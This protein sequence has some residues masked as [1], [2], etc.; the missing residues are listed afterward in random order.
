M[1]RTRVITALVLL[2]GLLAGIF[3]LPPWGWLALAAVICA[4]AAWEWGGLGGFAVGPRSVFAALMGVACLLTGAMS[5]LAGDAASAAGGLAALYFASAMFWVAVVPVWLARKWRITGTAGTVIVGL[6]VLLPP[7]LALAHLRMLGPWLLLA[8][9]AATFVSDIAAYFTGRAFGRHKLAPAISPGKTWEGA[10][11][12]VA[13]VL[14]FALIV[15]AANAPSMLDAPTVWLVVPLLAAFTAVG[16]L[17]DLFESLLKRQAGVKDSGSMLPGHGGILDRI[18]SLTST[19][20][21][22]GLAALWLAL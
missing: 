8:V 6:V 3:L 4:A 10:G 5:G 1:L 22:A 14:V 9:M 16:V 7:A 20:P 17:G 13:G 2:A 19:L 15:L 12:A 18:D 11:G 21:L